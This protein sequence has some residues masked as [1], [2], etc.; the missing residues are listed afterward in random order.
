MGWQPMPPEARRGRGTSG[1]VGERPGAGANESLGHPP[2]L[3]LQHAEGEAA[4][5]IAPP[6]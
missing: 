3:N 4:G 1:G 6:W 5:I 2:V